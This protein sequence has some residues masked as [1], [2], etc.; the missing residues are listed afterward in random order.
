MFRTPPNL[1]LGLRKRLEPDSFLDLAKRMV[2]ENVAE[3]D[4]M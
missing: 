2:G 3:R 1:M 4:R